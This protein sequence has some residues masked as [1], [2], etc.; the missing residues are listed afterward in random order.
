MDELIPQ[1]HKVASLIGDAS[2]A[3]MLLSLIGGQQL[4]AGDLARKAHISASTASE[5]LAKLVD[6]GLLRT[7]AQGRHRYYK[8]ANSQVAS[9]LETLNVLAP[10]TPIRSLRQSTTMKQ[11]HL[12]RTCYDHLAGTLG[13]EITK[14]LV[15]SSWLEPDYQSDI[16]S[17]TPQGH[18][19]FRIWELGLQENIKRPLIRSCLDWSERRYHVAGQ[20]GAA[21]T[22][23]FF[24]QDWIKRGS[25][26]RVIQVT[27]SGKDALCDLFDIK[28]SPNN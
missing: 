19:Q 14:A 15:R 18:K 21:I 3:A 27:E 11:L 23:W 26:A 7:R 12:G 8:L 16:L 6:A 20:L 2:R 9:L 13:V 1:L 25:I 24:N 4:P 22:N 17:I 28:W 5:H 10:P